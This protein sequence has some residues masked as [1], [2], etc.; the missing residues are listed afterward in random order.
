MEPGE[1][2]VAACRFDLDANLTFTDGWIVLTDRRLLADRPAFAADPAAPVEAAA[3][4]PRSWRLAAADRLD[5]HLRTAVGR[6]EFSREGAVI[7]RWLFTPAR[8]ESVHAVENAFDARLHGAAA[9]A[10]ARADT[11]PEA[12]A[13][14]ASETTVH[15][16]PAVAPRDDD[17]DDQPGEAARRSWRALARVITFARPH[18]GRTLLGW[19]LS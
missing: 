9:G 6:I 2:V 11:S 17:E 18:L 10:T 1:R 7:A 5:V 19:A 15:P 12:A 4:T 16:L 8:A 3:A 13:A 14:C